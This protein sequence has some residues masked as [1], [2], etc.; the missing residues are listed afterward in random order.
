M[1]DEFIKKVYVSEAEGCNRR[2][3]PLGR[4]VDRVKNMCERIA[5]G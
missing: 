1:S 5:G 3:G 4:W 2:G